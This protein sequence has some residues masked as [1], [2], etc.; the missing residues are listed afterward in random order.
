MDRNGKKPKATPAEPPHAE[1]SDT[2]AH[3]RDATER[4]D[5]EARTAAEKA[6]ADARLALTTPE[7][8]GPQHL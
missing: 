6:E 8:K 2:K 4:T 7:G 3:L 5:A 1:R